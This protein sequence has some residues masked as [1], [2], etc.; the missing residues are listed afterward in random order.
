[1]T[2]L[3]QTVSPSPALWSTMLIPALRTFTLSLLP[4]ESWPL[5][6]LLLPKSL[7]PLCPA[8]SH[9]GQ[10]PL[11]SLCIPASSPLGL[12]AFRPSLRLCSSPSPLQPTLQVCTTLQAC[13]HLSGLTCLVPLSFPL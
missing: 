11:F 13:T 2:I 9:T 5:Y 1:M 10:A 4:H 7:V 6:L 8:R 3:R 12:V